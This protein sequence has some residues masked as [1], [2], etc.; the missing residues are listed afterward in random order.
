[1]DHFNCTDGDIIPTNCSSYQL[2]AK[3][4]G[5]SVVTLDP[6]YSNEQFTKP[7]MTMSNWGDY[8]I[9]A[10]P[11]APEYGYYV[12]KTHSTNG[13][14]PVLLNEVQVADMFAYDYTWYGLNNTYTGKLFA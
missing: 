13:T 6:S 14:S 4:W 1:M 2:A 12:T 9:P 10:L 8:I 7:T 11:Q 5:S 3:Q